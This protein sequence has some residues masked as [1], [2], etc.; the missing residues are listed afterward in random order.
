M[1]TTLPQDLSGAVHVQQA[2]LF[3]QLHLLRR[4]EHQRSQR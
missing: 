2:I 1:S 4:L 3:E